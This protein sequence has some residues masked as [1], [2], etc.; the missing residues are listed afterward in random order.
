MLKCCCVGVIQMAP[1]NNRW[2][3]KDVPIRG[4]R[5]SSKYFDVLVF[6]SID[7]LKQ[8]GADTDVN[9]LKLGLA[10]TVYRT[11]RREPLGKGY[12]RGHQL[13]QKVQCLTRNTSV[14]EMNPCSFGGAMNANSK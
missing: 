6:R 1:T 10:E 4:V 7:C 2:G 3:D 13:P 9:R 11:S 5:F 14:V 12:Q 8:P